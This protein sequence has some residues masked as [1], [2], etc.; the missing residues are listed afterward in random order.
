MRR[1]TRVSL[2]AVLA[3]GALVA[4]CGS[5]VTVQGGNDALQ[6]TTL[7]VYSNLPILGSNGPVM[8]SI[9]NGELIALYD[10]GGRV[11][12]RSGGRK[13]EFHVSVDS[14]NDANPDIGAWTRESTQLTA[15][16]ASSDLSSVAYIGDFDS[17]ASAISIPLDNEYDVLQLSP[18]SPYLGFTDTGP[19]VLE[20]DPPNY[21]PYGQPFGQRTFARLVP[22]YRQEATAT[23]AYMRSLGVRRL[24]VLDDPADPLD[25]EIAP[26]VAAA[27]PAAG[28][29]VVGR[30]QVASG[31]VT[32]PGG[33]AVGDYAATA[34]AV[35]AAH[36]DAV[37][38][39]GAPN[40]GAS[41]LW[42]ALHR[43]APGVRLFAPSTL[44]VPAFLENLTA[45]TR[46]VTYITSPYLEPDQYPPAAAHVLA[47]YR[48]LF[49]GLEPTV[50]ALYGYE[51]M[52]DVLAAI[53]KA[54][55][56]AAKRTVL[57]SA[58]FH[59]GVIHGVI[60][61]YRILPSGDTTLDSFDGYRVGP[62]GRLVLV[63]RIS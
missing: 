4:G 3:L 41:V 52:K 60:G 39:G 35:A 46:P 49:P 59:L 42:S 17:G 1:P 36:P 13:R 24:Y 43:A 14:V 58:F 32:V 56:Y 51:A 34:S 37:L 48:T 2:A 62:A 9:V 6:Q 22:S 21:Y 7:T 57:T 50:Y 55:R 11:Q 31:T 45:A 23:L 63:R 26:L 61:T 38:F 33:Q 54:G 47:Q 29:E 30:A 8:D 15:R 12:Y 25:A 16:T 27:A 5:N 53:H 40:L 10:A 19:G 18:G 20:G 28:I 44:A